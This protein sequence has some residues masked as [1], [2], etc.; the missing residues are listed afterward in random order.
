MSRL[1]AVAPAVLLRVG[2]PIVTGGVGTPAGL[3]QQIL[4]ILAGQPAALPVGA[5]VL[6][7]VVEEADV[8]VLLLQGLDLPHDEC[9]QLFEV[10][11]QLF[12]DVEIHGAP[13]PGSGRAIARAGSPR[14][15]LP[16]ASSKA[17]AMPPKRLDGCRRRV[18]CGV[19]A[20][21][22]HRR[23]NRRRAGRACGRARPRRGPGSGS[24]ARQE[25]PC[26]T[27]SR[28]RSP[29]SS[30]RPTPT[31]APASR[32]TATTWMRDISSSSTSGA[33][34]TGT[35]RRSTSAPRSTRTGT[36]PSASPTWT[37]RVSRAK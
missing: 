14:T 29:T 6:A 23:R 35:R 27:A 2:I 28:I 3:G 31:R 12:R 4:P 7:A 32:D 37:P 24:P 33:A 30:S 15:T 13:V 16:E 34:R 26:A 8:V 5:G 19:A 9:V 36:M 1:L 18:C 20:C 11:R 22:I 21:G 10:A 25:T 17:Y